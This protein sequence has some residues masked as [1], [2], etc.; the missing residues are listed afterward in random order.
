MDQKLIKNI[1][2]K[3][4]EIKNMQNLS[5]KHPKF[6]SWHAS[7]LALLKGLPPEKTKVLNEFKK[8]TFEDTKYHRGKNVFEPAFDQK[9]VDDL[10]QAKKI[11]TK[12]TPKKSTKKKK[13]SK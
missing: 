8:L 6:K 10:N 3:I 13:D 4:K 7:T 12:L 1:R 5:S 2:S 9:F 11:L